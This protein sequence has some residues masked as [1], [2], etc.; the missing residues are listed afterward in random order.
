[1][2]LRPELLHETLAE[3]LE[4]VAFHGKLSLISER[5]GAVPDRVRQQLEAEPVDR[6]RFLAKRVLKAES[7]E[8]IGLG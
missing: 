3:D 6:L 2:L 7:L 8:D 4:T 5:F 1:M